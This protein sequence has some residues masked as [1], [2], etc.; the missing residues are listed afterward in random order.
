MI[1]SFLFAVSLS[2]LAV[3]VLAHH[4]FGTFDLQRSVTFDNA[5]LVE[6]DF[7]N[8]HSWMYFDVVDENG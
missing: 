8:P 3:P 4:G 7:I 5:V 6:V 2:V 1:R